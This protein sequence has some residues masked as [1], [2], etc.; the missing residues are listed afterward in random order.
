MST[1][2]PPNDETEPAVLPEAFEER[3]RLSLDAV[4]VVSGEEQLSYGE[5]NAR[6]NRLARHLVELG[7]GPERIVARA[8]P[9]SAETVVAL[10]AVLKAGGAYLPVDPEYPAE[11]VAFML[12]DARWA[13]CSSV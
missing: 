6:A 12:R 8:L 5:L 11:R 3:V 2:V 7:V 1:R 10:L 13:S 4:S 9:R